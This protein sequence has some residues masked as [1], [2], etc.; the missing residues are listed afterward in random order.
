MVTRLPQELVETRGSS[1]SDTLT[2]TDH[3]GNA[4]DLADTVDYICSQ[5]ADILGE[6]SWE[7]APD[8][9][10]AAIQAKT[11]MD[12]KLALKEIHLL[13]DIS[14]PAAVKATGSIDCDDTGSDVIPADGETF[15]LD[16]GI[17]AAVT[18]EFDTNSSVTQTDTL[19]QVDISAA[20]DDDDVKTAIISAVTGAPTLDITATS[21]GTGIVT[22]TNDTYGTVGNVTITET[23]TDA[24]FAVS[25]MSS[26]AGD[27]KVL[28]VAGSET[29][30]G[31]NNIKAV[32]AGVVQ[33]LVCATN[34]SFGTWTADEVAGDNALHPKNLLAVFNATSGAVGDPITTSDDKRIWALLQSETGATDNSAF[35]DTTPERAQ[36]SFVVQNDA[37]TDLVHVDGSEI[38]G[39]DVRLAF[40]DR[41]DL[42]DWG[43]QDFLYRTA[44]V[45][46]GS[47][48]AAGVNLN[49]VIDNQSTTPATQST[50]VY[51]RI[52]D[53]DTLNFQ[54]STGAVDMLSLKPAAAGDEL[55]INVDTLDVNVGAAGV[56][57]FDNGA[58]VDSGGQSINLG[59]T[60]G[61]VDSTTIKVAA[62]SQCLRC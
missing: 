44:F 60:A 52:D 5:L 25:G 33:G 40:I 17:N 20:A 26:G 55:E 1:I 53:D 56:I 30:S 10:I 42:D 18:F 41:E 6:S 13:T 61:Q 32:G 4:V 28:S 47:G 15:V 45:D 46:L 59:T 49:N 62:T 27:M 54:D 8:I 58:T 16:D 23:V 7:T 43:E 19:R 34:S 37:G 29:P 2:P 31:G 24:K 3:D 14:V 38:G 11:F 50:D 36:I 12:E 21:G 48:A 22:L 57:N 39:T 51:W 35:T 9:S